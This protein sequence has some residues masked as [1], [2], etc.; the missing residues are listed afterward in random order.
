MRGVSHKR[1]QVQAMV[2]VGDDKAIRLLRSTWTI[3]HEGQGKSRTL[4]D[5]A[6][7]RELCATPPENFQ[8]PLRVL[9][10]SGGSLGFSADYHLAVK[11][12]LPPDL[13][14]RISEIHALAI[15]KAGRESP[16][17]HG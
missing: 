13:E 10:V 7:S 9:W 17:G 4:I 16:V 15:L 11:G 1:R 14:E 6:G 2:K 8:R 12:V 5:E 3:N